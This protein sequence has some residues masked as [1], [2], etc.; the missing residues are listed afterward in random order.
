MVSHASY[1]SPR[2]V[3]IVHGLGSFQNLGKIHIPNSPAFRCALM[4]P[5]LKTL[6]AL[7]WC[8]IVSTP[9]PTSLFGEDRKALDEKVQPVMEEVD[10]LCRE[11]TVYII[12]PEKARRLAELVRKKKTETR[13]RVWNRGWLF[14]A[15]DRPRTES[16]GATVG[17]R[18]RRMS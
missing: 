13:C 7:F 18:T 11:K 12:G 10:K 15:V 9:T 8:M 5:F 17:T 6:I 3:A 1:D 2:V 16:G 14:G 4:S